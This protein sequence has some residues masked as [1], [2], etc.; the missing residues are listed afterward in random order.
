MV[1]GYDP[2]TCATPSPPHLQ[3]IN[4]LLRLTL[5]Y[6]NSNWFYSDGLYGWWVVGLGGGGM[7]WNQLGIWLLH[8]LPQLL[9]SV[10]I[11]R[12]LLSLVFLQI[13]G[14]WQVT[15]RY[16]VQKVIKISAI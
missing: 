2:N 6:K 9:R 13:L 15:Q 14:Q 16:T 4:D 1:C 8:F 12:T 3:S 11:S 10:L 7:V 5:F